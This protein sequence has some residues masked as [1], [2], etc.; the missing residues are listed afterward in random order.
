MSKSST[1]SR[2]LAIAAVCVLGLVVG[3]GLAWWQWERY[4]SAGGTFQNLGYVLQWPLFGL[5][6]L[7]MVRRMRRLRRQAAEQR[8]ETEPTGGT[9]VPLKQ[10]RT[11]APTTASA[12]SVAR[13]G[14][15]DDEL[16][17]YNRY[18]AELNARD[19]E[20]N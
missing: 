12:R 4:S 14:P 18:L 16:A 17:A 6:P 5:F 20:G 8:T 3:L 13:A 19:R 1:V 10:R 2:G 15:A 11:D 9:A 7:F